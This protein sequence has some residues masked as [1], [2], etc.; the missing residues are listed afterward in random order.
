[1][2]ETKTASAVDIDIS[3]FDTL[4]ESD[5]VVKHPLSGEPTT[6]TITFA[7]PGHP[8]SIEYFDRIARQNL[9]EEAS[10]EQARVN[11]RKWK[12]E[13]ESLDARRQKNLEMIVS[14]MIRWSPVRINGEEMP[15]TPEN[16]MKL[17]GDRKKGDLFQQCFDFLNAEK[18]FFPAS[19][20]N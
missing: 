12:A 18:S 14:R 16:A 9:R 15:F 7:G 5:M 20:K 11:G 1:M 13:D 10:K 2:S 8:K 4:D 17:L 6:W 3:E 19:A